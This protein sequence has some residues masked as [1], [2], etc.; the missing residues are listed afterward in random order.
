M[1]RRRLPEWM[2]K[3][4]TKERFH[5]YWPWV[6]SSVCA[7]LYFFNREPF[8]EAAGTIVTKIRKPMLR[9][10][11]WI[12]VHDVDPETMSLE[13][14]PDMLFGPLEFNQQM[15]FLLAAL[16]TDNELAD[17][18]LARIIVDYMDLTLDPP[19][20]KE[21]DFLKAGGRELLDFSIE[22]FTGTGS[23][24]MRKHI[25]FQPNVFLQLVNMLAP[26]PSLT[27][28]FVN[29]KDG[30]NL[31]LQ[32]Y[33]HSTDEYSR[34]M[35]TRALTLFAFTQKKDGNVERRILQADGMKTLIEA[36]KLSTGD[37]TDTRFCT[38]LLSSLL[39]HYPKEAGKEFLEAE[40]IEATIGNMNIARYKGIPQHLR[41]LRDAQK[42][43]KQ[44][45]G[46]TAVN[47]RIE[48]AEFLGLPSV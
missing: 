4:K 33:R 13:L 27:E 7:A 8:E 42:L 48:D 16:R 39:R 35:A 25:F 11:E 15:K 9:T 24:K 37:P 2:A 22:D 46:N 44:A 40:G 45:Y 19:N 29:E 36:Y 41:V 21:E 18:Y 28:Y 20:L 30:I 43:P 12:E 38:L 34:V 47:T 5:R 14:P 26:Y 17:G 32:A 31:V 23:R 3:P 1:M 10:M 6:L